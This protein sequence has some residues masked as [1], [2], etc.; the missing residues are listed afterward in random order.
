MRLADAFAPEHLALHA[1]NAP[2]LVAR[3]SR[4][5][6]VF[7][8]TST[9]EA[10]GDYLA[11]PSHVLPTAGTARFASPLSVATFR[12]RMSV[13]ELTPR[14][15]AAVAPAVEA[16]A[17]AEGLEG[18]WRAVAVRVAKERR[19]PAAAPAE[20]ARAGAPAAAA[21]RGRGEARGS[22]AAAGRRTR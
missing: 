3:L 4:A 2:A 8:G 10:V 11:G 22:R 1:R 7:V 21:R 18:H 17:R 14:A 5:G 16:L 20:E 13:L 9:P 19:G 15:L 6:A 12:R